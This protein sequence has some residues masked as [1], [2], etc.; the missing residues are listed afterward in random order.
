[1]NFVDKLIYEKAIAVLEYHQLHNAVAMFKKLPEIQH[2]IYKLTE[3]IEDHCLPN[4][5]MDG[6][7]YLV[8]LLTAALKEVEQ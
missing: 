6:D 4:A 3:V 5:E 1:M 8:D 7:L 2:R